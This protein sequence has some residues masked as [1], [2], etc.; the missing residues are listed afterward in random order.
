[1]NK[2]SA[3]RIIG[4][5]SYVP[6]R[7]LTNNDLEKM[8]D[9]SDE[10]IVTRT[11]IKERHIADH[12]SASSDL[13][14]EAA[15]HALQSAGISAD[16]LDLIIVATATP[17][18]FFPSTACFIQKKIGAVHA[19]CFDISAACSGFLY[20]LSIADQFIHT[21]RYRYI[22]IVG[23]EKF[24]TVTDWHDRNTC[25][26]FGDGAGAAVIAPAPAGE[27]VLDI[28]LGAD[29]QRSDLLSIPGGGSRIP[30]SHESIDAHQH[31]I[32]MQ[33][34]EVFK[35]AVIYMINAVESVLERCALKK[36]EIDLV[37]THQANIRIIQAI[38]KRLNMPDEKVFINVQKYGNIS[39]ASIPVALDEAY[40]EGKI[41][42]G[43]IV[44]LAAFG[45]GFTWGAAA[46]RW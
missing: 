46:V 27:G 4:L 9:T 25:V 19:A 20:S 40:K 16:Q 1:M 36:E 34:Q 29:G 28:V 32:K 7:I 39:A 11:G 5:G 17:D 33:G 23:V 10:W 14:T 44:V 6:P 13:G 18:M 45:G 38:Q 31:F 15:L 43:D 2:S 3:S 35:N 22:L 30:A 8:V 42:T 37:V 41:H 26:L 24:S 12:E 21:G